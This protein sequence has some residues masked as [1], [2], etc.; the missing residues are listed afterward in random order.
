MI[1]SN[2]NNLRATQRGQINS[3]HVMLPDF[4]T[5]LWCAAGQLIQFVSDLAAPLAPCQETDQGGRGVPRPP[6]VPLYSYTP[7]TKLRDPLLR[8]VRERLSHRICAVSETRL[9]L[10]HDPSTTVIPG[11][12]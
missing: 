4:C 1:A 10:L 7:H 12:I 6:V 9:P 5:T 3:N 8:N 11:S 2:F